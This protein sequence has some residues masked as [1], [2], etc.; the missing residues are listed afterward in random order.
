VAPIFIVL[1]VASIFIV[2]K[3]LYLYFSLIALCHVSKG[4][5]SIGGILDAAYSPFNKLL[6][7][8]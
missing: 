4:I 6:T 5:K 2:L 1:V 8:G 3:A 7:Q